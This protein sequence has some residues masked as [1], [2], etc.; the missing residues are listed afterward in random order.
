MLMGAD[1]ISGFG[2]RCGFCAGLKKGAMK[3]RIQHHLF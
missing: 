1:S 3:E 2:L